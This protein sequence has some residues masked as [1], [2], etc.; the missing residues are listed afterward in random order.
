M[1]FENILKQSEENP[2]TTQFLEVVHEAVACHDQT[3]RCHYASHEQ[4][5]SFEHVE[6]CVARYFYILS[7]HLSD[8]SQVGVRLASQGIGYNCEDLEVSQMIG[9]RPT[10]SQ[11][12]V[13]RHRNSQEKTRRTYY[14]VVSGPPMMNNSRRAYQKIAK[15]MLY[16]VPLIL[17]S[18]KRPSIF[19]LPS[20]V[21]LHSTASTNRQVIEHTNV[22]AVDEGDEIKY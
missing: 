1:A 13:S 21:S 9:G 20:I 15:A 5:R 8:Q 4:R 3:P 14:T 12:P 16:C 7:Q 2:D 19:A 10:T 6:D 11:Q 17:R 22:C 18:G